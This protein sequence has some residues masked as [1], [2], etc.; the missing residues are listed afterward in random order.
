[1]KKD[2]PA[3][4]FDSFGLPCRTFNLPIPSFTLELIELAVVLVAACP[5]LFWGFV[6]V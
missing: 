1:M 6:R 3:T 4:F 2:I 5:A